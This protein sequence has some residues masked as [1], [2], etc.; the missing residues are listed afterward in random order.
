VRKNLVNLL[1][2]RR[3]RR[4]HLRKI[5]ERTGN[6]WTLVVI[7]IAVG[8]EMETWSQRENFKP[9]LFGVEHIRRCLIRDKHIEWIIRSCRLSGD[10]GY[11]IGNR[12][13]FK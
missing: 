4:T 11:G 13:V 1:G 2:L 12:G 10:V 5:V 7:E 6:T 3:N 9:L 8:E